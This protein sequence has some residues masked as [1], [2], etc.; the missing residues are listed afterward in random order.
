M[1]RITPVLVAGALVAAAF[2]ASGPASATAV[3]WT[4]ISSPAGPDHGFFGFFDSTNAPSQLINVAGTAAA[5]VSTL[6]FYCFTDRDTKTTTTSPLNASP[7]AV[8]NGA[9]S[10]SGVPAPS[11]NM[12]CVLRAVPTSYGGLNGTGGNNG[13]VADF[14]GPTFYSGSKQRYVDPT[15]L[16]QDWLASTANRNVHDF[17][18][19][20][21]S[22][23]V[24]SMDPV[25]NVDDTINFGLYDGGVILPRWNIAHTHAAI[26]VDGKDAYPPGSLSNVTS[27]ADTSI[28]TSI[29]RVNGELVI[30]E[31]NPLRFC[32]GTSPCTPTQTGV[33]LDRTI[34]T[35]HGGAL[36][37]IRDR[38]V[39][40]DHA[41]HHITAEYYDYISANVAGVR[42]P[43]QSTFHVRADGSSASLPVGPHTIYLTSDVYAADSDVQR[44]DGGLTYSAHAT[45]FFAD[46]Y[47]FVMRYSR[48]V[49]KNGFAAFSWA[50]E[51]AQTVSGVAALAGPAQ[52]ALR[53]HLTLSGPRKTTADNTPV[54]RGRVTNAT[55]GL[56]GK[57]RVTI[58]SLTKTVPVGLGGGF[59]VSWPSLANGKH[60]VRVR[61]TDPSGIVLRA[62]RTF[63]IT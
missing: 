14:A 28:G 3:D 60:T 24:G 10:A 52:R 49:P 25:D 2:T 12:P 36:A 11:S 9:F 33:R 50:A 22:T 6:D 54:I 5:T 58:G 48:T 56:P 39:N 7:I 30:V 21:D 29:K 51:S 19:R 26:Q 59:A 53:P 37:I 17:F 42:L 1:R 16:T 23:G 8:T 34:R 63:T 18:G 4:R 45:A 61:A 41:R 62:A 57:V 32:S 40:V 43:G 15:G 27:T 35:S 46:S 47:E 44:T 31:H 38:F 20:V 13:Y 55:N